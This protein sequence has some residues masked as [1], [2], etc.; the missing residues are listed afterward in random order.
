MSDGGIR[1]DF[2]EFDLLE[3]L[4]YKFRYCSSN[5]FYRESSIFEMKFNKM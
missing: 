4:N 1:V 2:R 3:M 5:L